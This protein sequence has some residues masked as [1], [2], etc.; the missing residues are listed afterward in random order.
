M[1][2]VGLVSLNPGQILKRSS[3]TALVAGFVPR[4]SRSAFLLVPQSVPG[5]KV[6]IGTGGT[7]APGLVLNRPHLPQRWSL[8]PG[9]RWG[10]GTSSSTAPVP[11]LLRGGPL[12]C[13]GEVM[14]GFGGF[15]RNSYQNAA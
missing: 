3:G 4:K 5:V 15:K 14:L 8:R 11:S 6:L 2:A 9:R 12:E 7:R 10:C 13:T 1:A